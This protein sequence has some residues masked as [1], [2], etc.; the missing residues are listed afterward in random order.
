MTTFVDSKLLEV[1]F[2][3]CDLTSSVFDNCDLSRAT[4]DST[5]IEITDLRTSFNFS[6]DPENNRIKKALF[7]LSE[8]GGLLNKYDI[9][10][11]KT[12]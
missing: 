1:D 3:E 4:F 2:A 10:I 8:I 9:E 11:E 12:N 5:I 6:I 7:S